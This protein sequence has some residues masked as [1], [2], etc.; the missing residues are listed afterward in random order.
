MCR[1]GHRAAANAILRNVS[2]ERDW[3]A[4]G[5]ADLADD[6]LSEVWPGLTHDEQV[7]VRRARAVLITYGEP[8]GK[9]V[10]TT[11]AQVPAAA[12]SRPDRSPRWKGK[13][14]SSC[15]GRVV[16]W[17]DADGC[18]VRHCG[19]FEDADDCGQ[20]PDL[21]TVYKNKATCH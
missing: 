8:R 7:E 2:S 1:C 15:H 12:G 21:A 6:E 17:S 10:Y 19:W 9:T 5:L 11:A 13:V 14:R 18:H 4:N 3:L 20:Y 16:A